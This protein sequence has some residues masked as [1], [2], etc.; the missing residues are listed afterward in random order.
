MIWRV[1]G[2]MLYGYHSDPQRA[3]APLLRPVMEL[4]SRIV[5]VKDI[6]QG[7]A[8]SYGM[9]WR[10][11][12]R[13]RIATVPIGYGD[14]YCRLLSN[15]ASVIVIDGA[16]NRAMAPI[17]GR[18]CM[19]QLM[20]DIGGAPSARRGDEVILFG[21][22]QGMLGVDR[23]AVMAETISYELLCMVGARVRREY[24]D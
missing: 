7:M 8:I 3:S 21:D 1:Q 23:L 18:I 20:I 9:T 14:G 13:T 17:V 2:I 12:K 5:M 11:S 16:G 10:A 4:R 24:V 15:R 22:Q 19:D 6:E